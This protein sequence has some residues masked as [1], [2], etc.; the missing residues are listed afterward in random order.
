VRRQLIIAGFTVL[1]AGILLFAI[2]MT[3]KAARNAMRDADRY[4][5]PFTRIEC[6]TPPGLDREAF[7]GEVRYYG[8]FPE[9]VSVVDDTLPPRLSEALVRHPW[10]ER[11]EKVEL[12]PGKRVRAA[13]TFR[14]P[15]LAVVTETI[16]AVDARG[17]LLPRGADT[18]NLPHLR[19][20]SPPGA[21][22]RPW[23]D[24]RV[25]SVAAVAGLLHAHQSQLK[26]VDVR[27]VG[28]Q[29][30]LRRGDAPGAA[31]VIWGAGDDSEPPPALKLAR[32]L[33][34]AKRLDEPGGVVI[35]LRR[36]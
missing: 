31:E 34:Q 24:P 3:G 9:S 21:S 36:E 8:E 10:V 17:V 25:E 32:L 20:P 19:T 13:V 6:E 18:L 2:I 11:V 16:R 29:L 30:R 12:G 35:D 5:I 22:G 1:A 23:G 15:V 33:D 26:L 27:F 7:L 4:Q 28:D 14:T